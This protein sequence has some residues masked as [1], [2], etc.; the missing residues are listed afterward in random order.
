MKKRNS[1]DRIGTRTPR[2]SIITPSFNQGKYLEQTI[3]S[4]LDQGYPNLEYI[5]IDGGSTDGSVDII[6]KY[7][8]RFTYWVSEKDRGHTHAINKGL[9][10]SSGEILNWLN[11]DDILL[12]GALYNVARAFQEYPEASFI[13]GDTYQI[14]S[15]GELL[16]QVKV[17]PF[18]KNTLVYGRIVGTQPSV[19]FRRRVIEEIGPMDEAY[20]FC[21]DIEF[22][23]RAARG[24]YIFKPFYVPLSANRFHAGTKTVNQQE[25]LRFE[26]M[27][28][29][30]QLGVWF[31]GLPSPWDR[32]L[33]ELIRN[34]Y[35]LKWGI[36]RL[37]VRGDFGIN[38]AKRARTQA[39]SG[40]D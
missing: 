21:M 35:R 16:Y 40:T 28:I 14:N 24:G 13:Y 7:E 20:R 4:V 1:T 25:I 15:N 12:P 31:L 10:A 3:L 27:R 39:V 34:Y 23:I 36:T 8:D 29:L 38:R 2:I 33:Y 6:K 17:T 18:D 11:S 30:R 32:R 9:A 26:H 37:L 19:F 22:W 5:V